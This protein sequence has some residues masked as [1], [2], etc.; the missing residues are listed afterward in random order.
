M[1]RDDA[2]SSLLYNFLYEIRDIQWDE[3]IE[4]E[5]KY[6]CCHDDERFLLGMFENIIRGANLRRLSSDHDTSRLYYT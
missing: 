2:R 6:Y 3:K 4:V 1:D 5:R